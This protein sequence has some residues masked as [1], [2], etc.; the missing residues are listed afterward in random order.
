[1][2]CLRAAD[3][4]DGLQKWRVAANILNNQT[5]QPIRVRSPIWGLGE[6][7]INRHRKKKELVTK[8]YKGPRVVRILWKA[9]GL[10]WGPAA[11]SCEH[12]NEPSGSIKG[13]EFLE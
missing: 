5:G 1:M 7:L 12:D 4:G 2:V 8:W 6:G 9:S 10:G 3:G 13:E 11:G